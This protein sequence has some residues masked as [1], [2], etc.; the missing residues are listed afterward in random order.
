MDIAE[1]KT[2]LADAVSDMR[3]L[4]LSRASASA[5]DTF[6]TSAKVRRA[7]GRLF[8]GSGGGLLL[9]L[10]VYSDDGK[11][12]HVNIP[13]ADAADRLAELLTHDFAQLNVASLR[14]DFEARRAKDG[15]PAITKGLPQKKSEPGAPAEPRDS[16]NREK[17]LI[18]GEG[19]HAGFLT[20]LGLADGSGRI[21]DKMRPKYRQINRF[22]EYLSDV[23]GRLPAE[24]EIYALDL[25]C[26]KSYLTFAAYYYLT[27]IL[28]RRVK[29]TGVDL[30][31]DVIAYCEKTAEA[32]GW[33]GLSFICGDIMEFVPESEPDLVLSLHACDIATDIVL[34]KAARSGAKV[35]LSTPCC[36]HEL[37]TLMDPPP[38][39]IAALCAQPLIRHK[40]T[41][42]FTDALRAL[43]LEA[44]GYSVQAVELVDPEE[45][46]KNTLIRAV[47]V[48]GHNGDARRRYDSRA[49]SSAPAPRGSYLSGRR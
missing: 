47:K 40:L 44:Y 36:Q 9:Q 27:A 8:T 37:Y 28:G 4:T 19:A 16:H 21:K 10:A 5:R 1:F 2:K 6:G 24:G 32:L 35:I 45:T 42:A 34:A 46:P 17:N 31:P 23:V 38:A 30:K 41:D 12:R 22:L 13:A 14:G 7:E 33:D 29:M 25:C 11:V 20:A 43:Y 26:G 49:I 3:R 39:E 15:S 18:L 48:R